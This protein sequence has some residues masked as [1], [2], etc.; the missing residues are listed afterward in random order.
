M[1]ISSRG[2]VPENERIQGGVYVH[3]LGE[4]DLVW[5]GEIVLVLPL[6]FFLRDGCQGRIIYARLR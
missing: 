6:T 1:A 5:V 4:T 3:A 2:V